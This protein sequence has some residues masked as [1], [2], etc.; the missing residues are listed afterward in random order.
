MRIAPKDVKT[1]I[2][3]AALLYVCLLFLSFGILN[4]WAIEAE[5]DRMKNRTSFKSRL[6]DKRWKR[7]A[8]VISSFLLIPGAMFILKSI[9]AAPFEMVSAMKKFITGE[10]GKYGL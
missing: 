3:L 6:I 9:I 1:A 7:I 5:V 8:W 10:K 2:G 4:L